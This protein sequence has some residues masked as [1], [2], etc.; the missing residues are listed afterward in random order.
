MPTVTTACWRAATIKPEAHETDVEDA[1]AVVKQLT[2]PNTAELVKSKLPNRKPV[3]VTLD[4]PDGGTLGRTL[5]TTGASVVKTMK[6]V[7]ATAPIVTFAKF[8]VSFSGLER[9]WIEVEL[10]HEAVGQTALASC[11]DKV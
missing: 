5:D 4:L 6:A 11:I 9:H 3:T 1:Q 7:P 8:V 2:E 10:V